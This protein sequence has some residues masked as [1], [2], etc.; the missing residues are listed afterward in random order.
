MRTKTEAARRRAL[1]GLALALVL[2]GIPL[3]L[4]AM[5][6]FYMPLDMVIERGI[7]TLG[8]TELLAQTRESLG[9]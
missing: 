2:V 8:L 9:Q 6:R 3:G 1:I 7:R 4:W 5:S